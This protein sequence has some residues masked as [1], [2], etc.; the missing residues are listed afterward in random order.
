MR[1]FYLYVAAMGILGAALD[2]WLDRYYLDPHHR[3]M[4]RAWKAYT[5]TGRP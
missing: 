1:W 4:Q 2:W 3:A 5:R